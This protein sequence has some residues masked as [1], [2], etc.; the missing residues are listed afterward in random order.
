MRAWFTRRGFNPMR[1]VAWGLLLVFVF[2]IPWEYSLDL[3]APFGN[4]ARITGLLLLIAAVLAVLQARR[5]SR[6]RPLQWL[7][8]AFF[9]WF[10]CSLFWAMAPA[11]SLIKLRGYFQETMI[12]WLLWEFGES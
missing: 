2:T 12:V 4:I 6:P 5:F 9:L 1:R 3:G 7:T 10:C 8:L 11:E